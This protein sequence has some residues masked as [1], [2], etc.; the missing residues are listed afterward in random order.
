MP[1]PTPPPPSFAA[2][3]SS[4]QFARALRAAREARGLTYAG[5]AAK[6]R[7]SYRFYWELENGRSDA[8]L[9]K[10]IAVG[11]ALGVQLLLAAPGA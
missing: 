7:V 3:G 6:C 1:T 2:L 4:A 11:K 8:R 10:A 9:G 5:A